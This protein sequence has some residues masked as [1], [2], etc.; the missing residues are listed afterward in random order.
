MAATAT[1][2]RR[3]RAPGR[4]APT[5]HAG[6]QGPEKTR[7]GSARPPVA[8]PVRSIRP[9]ARP[10]LRVPP[11]GGSPPPPPCRRHPCP[12]RPPG[13]RHSSPRGVPAIPTAPGRTCLAA[14][15]SGFWRNPAS[16]PPGPNVAKAKGHRQR[17]QASGRPTEIASWRGVA[18]V[19]HR[20]HATLRKNTPR[21]FD[22][23]SG[24]EAWRACNGPDEPGGNGDPVARP[25]ARRGSGVV[26]PDPHIDK[27]KTPDQHFRR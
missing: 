14:I 15:Y 7:T 24:S 22:G 9:T 19:Q 6:G 5:R 10:C 21:S 2:P 26:G 4:M 12:G 17:E 25:S 23:P 27:G 16:D 3:V 11:R 18:N 20:V 8:L 13:R 1:W